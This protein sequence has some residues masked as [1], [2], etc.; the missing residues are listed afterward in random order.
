MSEMNN[1]KTPLARVAI[2]RAQHYEISEVR[3]A[4]SKSLAL[5]G[6]LEQV[7]GRD[8]NVFV[9]INHLPPPSP[10]E[11]GIVTHPVFA[12]AVLSL[13]KE[14]GANITV[15]DDI[16]SEGDD[17]F[18]LSGYREMCR[19]LDVKLVTLREA[20]FIARKCEGTI[21]K[22]VYIS[23]LVLESDV[24]INLPKFKTHSL[25]LLTGGIKNLY[26]VI[27]AGLR[28]QY[29]GDF[30]NV[31]DFCRALVDIY[32]L[33]QPQLSIMDGIMAMEGEGPGSG[34]VRHLG[35]ILASRDTVALDAIASRIAGLEH[36]DV[37]TTRFAAERGLGIADP[38]HIEI[39]GEKIEAVA[40]SD[41]KLPTTMS[42]TLM[43]RAPRALGRFAVSQ[44]SPR[45]YVRKKN[46]TAC[47]ECVKACPTG[48]VTIPDKKAEINQATC[49]R[50][51]CCHE[52]CRFDAIVP[53]KPFIGSVIFGLVNALRKVLK[54]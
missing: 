10:P 5:I 44:I 47:E 17:G 54:L 38:V 45:P 8:T 49:I 3:T 24:I 30:L 31:E 51:M 43:K 53:R 33:A 25:T 32:S 11:R 13:L 40:V 28:R 29:H 23:R 36:N 42:R 50:C 48:A 39:V 14:T 9:K 16:E 15:G 26:G 7:V 4:V 20:G 34:K 21:L 6:G 1:M 35:V 18:A 27:P 46:C 2:V 37:L 41:F 52:V 12:E 22:E 19:R